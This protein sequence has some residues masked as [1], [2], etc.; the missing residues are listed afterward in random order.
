MQD[1]V[2]GNIERRRTS[3]IMQQRDLNTKPSIFSKL[4]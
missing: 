4:L 1:Q 2:E 3:N